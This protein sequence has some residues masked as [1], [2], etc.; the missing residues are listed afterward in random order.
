[1][2]EPD[3]IA[4]L[5]RQFGIPGLATVSAG[6]GGLPRVL[7]SSPHAAGEMYLHGGHVT[8]WT[9]TGA[10]DAFYCSPNAVWHDGLAIRGGVPICFPWFGNNAAN[11][12]APAHGFVR[13]KTWGL[14]SVEHVDDDVAVSVFTVSTDDTRKWWP[15]DFHLVCRATFGEQLKLELI[16]TNTGS[17]PFSFEEALH[18]YFAIGDVQAAAVRGLD[19]TRY[20]DKVDH[21]T[22]KTQSGDIRISS[23]TDRIYVNTQHD[24]DL[25]DP[26]LSRPATIRKQN[27]ATTVVWNPWADKAAAM[28]DL[29]PGQWKKF[30]CVETANIGASSVHLGPGESHTMAARVICE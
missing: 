18:A 21:F 29:G 30:L 8:S 2:T 3:A 25:I 16:V 24:L 4:A 17:A 11:P 26:A 5:D 22:E 23:E 1:L 10:R 15:F 28:S 7:I 19:G 14:Q 9:P 20:I 6:H 13:T 12:A 27:S